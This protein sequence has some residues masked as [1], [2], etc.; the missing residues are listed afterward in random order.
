MK[1]K[2][3]NVL[4]LCSFFRQ[5][6]EF[7]SI[8]NFGRRAV[9]T[10]ATGPT[11]AEFDASKNVRRARASRIA[12]NDIKRNTGKKNTRRNVRIS[13]I[14]YTMTLLVGKYWALCEFKERNCG[15]IL[16]CA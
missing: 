4:V 11:S 16:K 1:A 13:W 6:N 12:Q 2:L 15:E 14:E 8:V 10:S 7:D 9:G 3:V 5:T